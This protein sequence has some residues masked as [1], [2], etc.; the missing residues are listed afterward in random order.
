MNALAGL[1]PE[2]ALAGGQILTCMS[3]GDSKNEPHWEKAFFLLSVWA[4][5]HKE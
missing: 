4:R 2:R 3:A 1:L 5:N